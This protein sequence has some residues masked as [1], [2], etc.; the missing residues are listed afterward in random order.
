MKII[1][2]LDKLGNKVAIPTVLF[3]VFILI[4]KKRLI[5]LDVFTICAYIAL[6][7]GVFVG[8]SAIAGYAKK[9]G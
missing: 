5:E 2:L 8:I 3:T 4:F 6:C 7:L 1:T 9:K